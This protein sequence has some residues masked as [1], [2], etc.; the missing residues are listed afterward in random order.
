MAN[1]EANKVYIVEA[2][3]N[4]QRIPRYRGNP[5]I[6]AL[7][8]M[9]SEET[10]SRQL[11]SLPDFSSEQL[12][13]PPEDRLQ[14]I[15]GLSAFL[16]PLERHIRLAR[17][18]DTLIRNGY[19]GRAPSTPEDATI[20]QEMYEAQMK[21]VA[22]LEMVQ[23]PDESQLSSSLIGMSGVGKTT[24]LRRNFRRYP[25][26]IYHP[27]YHIYQVPFLHIEA[28]HDG[29]SVKALAGAILRKLDLLVPDSDFYDTYVSTKGRW[30]GEMLLIN[31]AAHAMHTYK[32]GMLVVDEIQNL[33][34]RGTSKETL[35][36]ALVSAANQLGVPILF[37]GT[38]K[39][40]SVLGLNFRQG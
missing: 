31:L 33:S 28:P 38:N 22:F 10:L 35:M 3:Y 15:G 1:V 26:V 8:P 2:I 21:G 20:Y 34:N 7:P 37:V 13:W 29:M 27:K 36:S 6:E 25:H 14:M 4:E 39:A 18:L 16:L 17:A 9:P 11:L 23:T 5:L 24:A 40:L 30:S 19:V 12:A 32:V